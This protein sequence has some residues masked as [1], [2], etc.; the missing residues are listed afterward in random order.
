MNE[1]CFI[2]LTW[3]WG[4]SSSES[5]PLVSI[6]WGLWVFFEKISCQMHISEIRTRF[7]VDFYKELTLHRKNDDICPW[8][9]CPLEGEGSGGGRSNKGRLDR[10]SDA[11]RGLSPRSNSVRCVG[12]EEQE[13]TWMVVW[14]TNLQE[15]QRGLGTSPILLW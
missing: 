9:S 1:D 6:L 15:G 11:R 2:Y 8:L 12:C 14:G 5:I 13:K 3:M 4:D 7:I 10:N